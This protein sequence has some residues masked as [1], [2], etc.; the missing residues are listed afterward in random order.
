MHDADCLGQSSQ[1]R[2]DFLSGVLVPLFDTPIWWES[3]Y[4]VA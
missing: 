1:Q 2:N 4:P 3:L